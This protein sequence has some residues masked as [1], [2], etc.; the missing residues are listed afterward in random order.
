MLIHAVY[1][2]LH[3]EVTA[4]ERDRHANRLRALA[5]IDGVRRLHV[6][7]PAPIDRPVVESTYSVALVVA[8]DGLG[9]LDAYRDDPQHQAFLAYARPLWKR[10]VVY[11]SIE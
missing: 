3:D 10:Q 4:E 7:S 5:T 9:S 6:G 2:W 1:I 8:F 11:D